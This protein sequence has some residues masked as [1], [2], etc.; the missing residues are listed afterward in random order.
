MLPKCNTPHISHATGHLTEFGI[1]HYYRLGL[2]WL[3]DSQDTNLSYH[4]M[5]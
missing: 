2:F 3:A 5:M 4:V 1:T